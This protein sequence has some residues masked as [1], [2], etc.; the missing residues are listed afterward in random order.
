M[1]M[2]GRE[3]M[4][5]VY[6]KHIID[7]VYVIH[8]LMAHCGVDNGGEDT[9]KTSSCWGAERR[10]NYTPGLGWQESQKFTGP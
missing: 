3:L 9:Y 2:D 8:R 10:D 7:A 5:M 4:K 6:I 1:A